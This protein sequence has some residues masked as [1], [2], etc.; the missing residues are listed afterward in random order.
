[1]ALRH[2]TSRKT[3]SPTVPSAKASADGAFQ[4]SPDL[5]GDD[6]RMRLT[7]CRALLSLIAHGMA[8][9]APPFNDVRDPL[10][11]RTIELASDLVDATLAQM[12]Q[13]QRRSM[14]NRSEKR[15]AA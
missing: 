7:S 2:S 6:Q 11:R 1:M 10:F 12:R 3:R 13:S 5:S 9:G 8:H 4:L 14:R 15:G